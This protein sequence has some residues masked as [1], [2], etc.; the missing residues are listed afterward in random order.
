M[1]L[2]GFEPGTFRVLGERDNHYT[3]E[4]L[5]S[6]SGVSSPLLYFLGGNAIN[7][8]VCPAL[9]GNRTRV[10]RVAGENSTTEPPMPV[11]SS[12]GVSSHVKLITPIEQDFV[13]AYIP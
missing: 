13:P 5:H 3:T 4:T 7:F 9:A 10:S 12:C 1:F 6:C 2:P 11:G 8:K